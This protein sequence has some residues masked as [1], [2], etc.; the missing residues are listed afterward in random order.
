[1]Y[2]QC[3]TRAD[4]G[5]Y[6][7][8]HQGDGRGSHAA[9]QSADFIPQQKPCWPI[10]TDCQHACLARPAGS[11]MWHAHRDF[12]PN[13]TLY[14]VCGNGHRS[15]LR[16][17][18]EWQ[19]ATGNGAQRRKVEDPTLWFD[20]RGNGIVYHVWAA[21]PFEKLSEPASGH[22]PGTVLNGPSRRRSLLR[23]RST[24]RTVAPS[25]LQH[26]NGHK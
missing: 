20:Q 6:L 7:L 14:V 13:K 17:H 3:A 10:C 9:K 19:L 22:A 1:M 25:S 18:V 11:G 12:H 15:V 21:D 23:G 16:G 2:G 24:S 8:F 4:D 5:E 26:A